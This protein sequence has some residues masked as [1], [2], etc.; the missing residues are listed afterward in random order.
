MKLI[1]NCCELSLLAKAEANEA[2]PIAWKDNGTGKGSVNE[3]SN[4]ACAANICIQ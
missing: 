3:Q 2:T 4:K 1:R